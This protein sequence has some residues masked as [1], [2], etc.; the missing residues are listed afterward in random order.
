[1]KFTGG[2]RCWNGPS[3]SMTVELLCGER[4]DLFD[5]Q[6]PARCEYRSKFFT[7]IACDAK[8]LIAKKR[9]RELLENDDDNSNNN[10]NDDDHN[11]IVFKYNI[12]NY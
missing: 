9:E 12:V 3:R 7:P 4:E 5:V 11:T 10:G 1:M 8:D 6:E 2:E